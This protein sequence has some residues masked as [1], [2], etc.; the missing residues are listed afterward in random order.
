MQN[1]DHR[2]VHKRKRLLT[3]PDAHVLRTW[4]LARVGEMIYVESKP[5][6]RMSTADCG[7]NDSGSC[8]RF[9]VTNEPV[10]LHPLTLKL[11]FDQYFHKCP[12]LVWW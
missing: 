12:F 8:F 10:V 6:T 5:N 1:L 2:E 4:F 3:I 9:S 7:N 11:S